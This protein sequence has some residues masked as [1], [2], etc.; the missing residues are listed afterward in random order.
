MLLCIKLNV[1]HLWL[2]LL[3]VFDGGPFVD[4]VGAS[5]LYRYDKGRILEIQKF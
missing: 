1:M 2:G 5:L 3:A 4:R